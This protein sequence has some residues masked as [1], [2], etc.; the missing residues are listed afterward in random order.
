[1]E[2]EDSIPH[3]ILSQLNPVHT[4]TSHFLKSHLN[5]SSHLRLG[6][7]SGLFPSGF[8]TNALYTPHP[9]QSELHSRPSDSSWFYHPH[10]S[11]WGVQIMKLLMKF[12][13]LPCYLSLLGSNV[14]LNPI[15][16]QPQPTFLPQCQRPSFTHEGGKVVSPTQRPSLPPGNIP[17]THFW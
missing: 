4:P 17:G 5:I 16:K 7:P 6:L 8:P 9:S 1:M 13:P 15:L 3:S 14:I 12:S 10:N 11:R 2:P